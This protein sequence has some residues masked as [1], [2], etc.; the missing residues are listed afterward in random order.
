[1]L[2]ARVS[3]RLRASVPDP[4]TLPDSIAPA[5]PPAPTWSVAPPLVIVTPV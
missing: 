1:M 4:V 3:R 5:V 2:A